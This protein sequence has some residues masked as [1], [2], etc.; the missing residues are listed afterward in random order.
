M[1]T[2]MAKILCPELIVIPCNTEKYKEASKK[3]LGIV[4][5][6]DPE[7]ESMGMDEVKLDITEY[8]S[9]NDILPTEE[10]INKIMEEI[11]TKIHDEIKI[12]ASSGYASCGFLAKL[13]SE[14]NKP[15]GQYFLPKNSVA[16]QNFLDQLDVRKLPGVGPQSEAILNGL[17][18]NTVKELRE[19]LF[20]LFLINGHYKWFED[21]AYK[22]LGI[23]RTQHSKLKPAKTHSMVRTIPATN[24]LTVLTSHLESISSRLSKKL[25]L[26]KC[27]ASNVILKLKY[28]SFKYMERSS[29]L[30]GGPSR[31][32]EAILRGAKEILKGVMLEGRVRL[33]GIGL[34]GLKGEGET[35]QAEVGGG[36][37][38]GRSGE[39]KVVRGSMDRFVKRSCEVMK[40][41][42]EVGKIQT[43]KDSLLG[44]MTSQEQKEIEALEKELM[45]RLD[46][47]EDDT[48]KAWQSR[49]PSPPTTSIGPT[50]NNNQVISETSSNTP[51]RYSSLPL[52]EVVKCPIC[53]EDIT[54]K[55]F[56]S[57]LNQHIDSCLGKKEKEEKQREERD[58]ENQDLEEEEVFPT[59]RP[60][61]RRRPE[62]PTSSR[63]KT[64]KLQG[65]QGYFKPKET[66]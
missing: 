34:G 8:L 41:E 37:K 60:T 31:E 12:T 23:G 26:K 4:E 52:P 16:I 27:L 6:Y 36:V 30:R 53:Q 49:A 10:N 57:L 62:R 21:L 9:T 25:E 40:E 63:G 19:G 29:G 42:S 48:Q 56:T 15:N 64:P 32:K 7:Y 39:E 13:S 33:I 1:P 14:K 58:K 46:G 55:G 17:G 35:S 20:D 65:I 54:T 24:S 3:F 51:S 61:K 38:G 43:K 47:E 5:E 50:T 45:E 59:P 28:A 2:H 22:S 66:K 11:R 44:K 18:F